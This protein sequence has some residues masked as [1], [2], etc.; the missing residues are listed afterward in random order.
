MRALREAETLLREAV[1]QMRDVVGEAEPPTLHASMQLGLVL[2]AR[3]SLEEAEATLRESLQ[4]SRESLGDQHPQV[5]ANISHLASLAN[6]KGDTEMALMLH[7]QARTRRAA[8]TPK[9]LKHLNRMV[10]TWSSM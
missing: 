3:D 8:Q 5:L 6:K 2:M 1:S 7:Q 9:W 4:A 10:R